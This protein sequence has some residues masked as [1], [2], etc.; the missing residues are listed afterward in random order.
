MAGR[1]EVD[2]A[3]AAARRSFEAGVWCGLTLDARV[4]VIWRIAELIERDRD[5]LA[6]LEAL[7]N[8]KPL[9]ESVNI[10]P[11]STSPRW[12]AASGT[13]PAGPP[14]GSAWS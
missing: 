14:S 10:A 6:Q 4:S 2:E 12:P 11:T 8:G 9:F 13:S 7:D 1:A 5:V 3:V